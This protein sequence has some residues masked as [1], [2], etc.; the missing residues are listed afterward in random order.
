MYATGSIVLLMRAELGR[1]KNSTA[2]SFVR[3]SRK[4]EAPLGFLEA[5][6]K[7]YIIGDS[8]IDVSHGVDIYFNGK[9]AEEVGFDKVHKRFAVL[10]DLK[11]VALDNLC[12]KGIDPS[13]AKESE[14]TDG[15]RVRTRK[16]RETSPNITQL[17]L[18][19]NVI[20]SVR[21]VF[22]LCSVLPQLESL[23]LRYAIRSRACM[24]SSG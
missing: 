22:A 20:E 13:P 1:S 3:P 4:H 11:I 15:F 18:S 9:L 5:L 19:R 7:K 8:A 24:M 14:D 17:G 10:H 21:D 2:A 16:I 23:D 6:R 12:V